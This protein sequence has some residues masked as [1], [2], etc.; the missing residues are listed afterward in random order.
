M[1]IFCEQR[2]LFRSVLF[3]PVESRRRGGGGGAENTASLM[4]S[5]LKKG[6]SDEVARIFFAKESVTYRILWAD[7]TYVNTLYI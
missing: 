2:S 7:I 6:N 5:T 1:K 4:F 3:H